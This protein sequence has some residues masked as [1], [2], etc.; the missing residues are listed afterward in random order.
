MIPAPTSAVTIFGTR[1]CGD[2]DVGG[3]NQ[4]RDDGHHAAFP[5]WD[6]AGVSWVAE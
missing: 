1:S 2:E 6:A 3:E 4:H 5:A